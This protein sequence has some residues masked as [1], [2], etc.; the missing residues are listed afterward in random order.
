MRT[1]GYSFL[2]N[3][4]L[5]VL[6]RKLRML[7][8]DAELSA[9]SDPVMIRYRS[10]SESRIVLTKNRKLARSMG[11][12]AWLVSGTGARDEF[13]SLVPLLRMITVRTDP[14]SRCLDCNCRLVKAS[15]EQVRDSV[16][17]YPWIT[18]DRFSRC[19][20]CDKS[21]WKGTH[22]SRMLGEIREMEEELKG[23]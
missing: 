10:R 23:D 6:A 3:G 4:M 12:R 21:Y 17:H 19:P 13:R 14:L 8:L 22:H 18:A 5:G 2:L 16:P 11:E 20:R 9:D 1:D 7:G 15:R